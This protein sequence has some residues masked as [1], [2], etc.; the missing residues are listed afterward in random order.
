MIRV[1]ATGSASTGKSAV[2][3]ALFGTQF[4]VD[5]RS[6]STIAQAID[7]VRFGAAEIEVIDNPPLPD[8]SSRINADVYLL[9]CDKDLTELEFD[10]AVRICRAGRA[11]SVVL[12]KS[13]TYSGP[14]I[15]GLVQH[16][17]WRLRA[18]VPD[19]DI[20]AC[21]ADPV[22]LVYE[23]QPDGTIFEKSAKVSADTQALE[24]VVRRLI[25]QAEGTLRVRTR[26]LAVRASERVTAFLKERLR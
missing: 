6:R 20:V 25:S 4:V 19:S 5:P 9:V 3:N 7:V 14:Q 17:R 11:L 13:D 12:N 22:R 15:A 10:E 8:S 24:D 26:E 2:L 18:L 23:G 16:I 21:A 1:A